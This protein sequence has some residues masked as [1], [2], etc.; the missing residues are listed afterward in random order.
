MVSDPLGKSATVSQPYAFWSF[1]PLFSGG[2]VKS[3]ALSSPHPSLPANRVINAGKSML[4]ED[5]ASCEKLFVK[6]PSSKHR[7][8]TLLED[9]RVSGWKLTMM[10]A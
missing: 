8:S 1:S 2:G 5:Q 9:N 4:N 7:N 10:G 6:K 3:V